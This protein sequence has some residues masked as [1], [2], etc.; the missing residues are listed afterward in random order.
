M[1]KRFLIYC[2]TNWCGMD[3]EY[4][5]IAESEDQLWDLAEELAY[6]N[7]LDYDLWEDI[8]EDLG[9]NREEMSDEEWEAFQST[10]DESAYYSCHIEEFDGSDEE[11]N[12]YGKPYEV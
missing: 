11:W 2:T 9:Y 12:E 8:A 4:P 10:V 7:F 5:V 1:K 3:N 6:N